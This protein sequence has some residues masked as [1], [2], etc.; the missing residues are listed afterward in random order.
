MCPRAGSVCLLGA[1]GGGPWEAHAACSLPSCG[2]LLMR[3]LLTVGLIALL[4]LTAQ[5]QA[6]KNMDPIK[7]VK[8]DRKDPVVY[9]KDIEPIFYKRCITCHSGNVKE[10]RFDISNYEG[11][12]KGGKRGT[13]ITPGKSDSSLLYKVM[14]RTAK[15]F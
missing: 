4:P 13:A 5:A 11:L 2:D 9:E 10:S 6:K 15:P 12:V 8:L 14:A 3:M 1:Q 7:V